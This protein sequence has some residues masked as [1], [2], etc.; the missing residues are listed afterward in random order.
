MLTTPTLLGKRLTR[1]RIAQA[2]KRQCPS[3]SGGDCDTSLTASICESSD[4]L[5]DAVGCDFEQLEAEA[6]ASEIRAVNGEVI[7]LREEIQR[8]VELHE[9]HANASALE[10]ERLTELHA[11]VRLEDA[12][13]ADD[14]H[15]DVKCLR[16]KLRHFSDAM[17]YESAA[18]VREIKR[19]S[20]A[21]DNESSIAMARMA[22]MHMQTCS[23][24]QQMIDKLNVTL[25]EQTT[26]LVAVHERLATASAMN[27]RHEEFM[28]NLSKE[29]VVLQY[30][31]DQLTT[32][33]SL[34]SQQLALCTSA[35]DADTVQFEEMEETL[36]ASLKQRVEDKRTLSELSL[37]I[38]ASKNAV[39]TERT[40]AKQYS[41]RVA[42]GKIFHRSLWDA[43][44]DL[45]TTRA[46]VA[47]LQ[48]TLDLRDAE[49]R[50]INT[51][52]VNQQ[53]RINGLDMRVL[54]ETK[55]K[56]LVAKLQAECRKYQCELS[57]LKETDSK[58][59]AA[60]RQTYR[61][62]L[63]EKT[64][65]EEALKQARVDIDANSRRFR[66]PNV[67]ARTRPTFV[68]VP[69]QVDDGVARHLL[70][71]W[72]DEKIRKFMFN[73]LH[74]DRTVSSPQGVKDG[75]K[76]VLDYL[77]ATAAKPPCV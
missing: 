14:A 45:H 7:R 33:H 20:D 30:K 75:A 70:V 56:L 29:G 58:E 9:I 38:D 31:I 65:L 13:V 10:I 17:D 46:A 68:D 28:V 11:Q 47:R 5:L 63:V 66:M 8:S 16:E 69:R 60:M 18:S 72:G 52:V 21:K 36:A 23:E 50:K 67:K 2:Q 24:K 48:G 22:E 55:L 54:N 6:H 37:Q 51:K 71:L 57:Q 77:N 74:S 35:R 59:L 64:V 42:D 39:N 1:S 27:E 19:L 43:D 73:A 41:R 53:E 44:C 32:S 4:A 76:H 3:D 61:E 12:R 40:V 49:L 26:E 15:A 25:R 34:I 62:V